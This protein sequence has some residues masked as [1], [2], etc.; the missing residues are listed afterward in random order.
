MAGAGQTGGAAGQ[1]SVAGSCELPIDLGDGLGRVGTGTLPRGENEF[2]FCPGA[3][4]EQHFRWQAPAT[5]RYAFRTDDS[6]F[7]TVLFAQRGPVCADPGEG[8]CS[9]DY[10]ELQSLIAMQL[11]GGDDVWLVIDS[12]GSLRGDYVL[13]VQPQGSCPEQVVSPCPSGACPPA[14]NVFEVATDYQIEAQ[15]LPLGG[16]SDCG[17]GPLGFSVEVRAVTEGVYRFRVDGA[18]TQFDPVIALRADC[19]EA[20]F[21]CDDDGGDGPLAAE[22]DVPLAE[23]ESVIVEIGAFELPAGPRGGVGPVTL[24]VDLL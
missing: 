2:D 15:P 1:G 4:T 10:Y 16:V 20:T 19:G 22:L 7:D 14:G 23:G 18:A 17:G 11:E 21:A 12:F 9:D 6:E 13:E 24:Q 5:G 3:G 8:T